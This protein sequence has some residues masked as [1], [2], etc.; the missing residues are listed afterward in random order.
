MAALDGRTPSTA[1]LL[2]TT[3]P[4]SSLSDVL[5]TPVGDAPAPVRG[6][7]GLFAAS[8]DASRAFARWLRPRKAELAAI[9]V[10]GTYLDDEDVLRLLNLSLPGI[11]EVIGLLEIV[12]M[13]N[14]NANRGY[15]RVV[16]DT[17]PTGHTMRLLEAPALLT[18]V[19]AV[20]DALQSHHRAV[21]AA[22]RGGYAADA[23]DAFI[24]ELDRDGRALEG[25]LRDP[26]STELTWVTLPEP[27]ALEETFDAI[28]ALQSAG[29]RVGRLIVNRFTPEAPDGCAFCDARRR[30][31]AR[32]LV[33]VAR[34]LGG[35]DIQM[36]PDLGEEPR[37]VRALERAAASFVPFAPVRSL[38]PI[39]HRVRA[40]IPAAARSTPRAVPAFRPEFLAGEVRWLLFGGKGGVGKSTCAAAASLRLAE[41]RRVLLLSTDPAHSLADVFG[42]PLDD[43]ARPIPGGPSSLHVREIDASAGFARYRQRYVDA[44]DETF[45][46]ISRS[47]PAEQPAFRDL[48]DL[49]PPGIDEVIAIAEVASALRAD[50]GAY[51]LVVTD[52]APTGHALRLLHT[53]AIL[54][55]WTKALMTILRKYREIV[56]AG[57]LAALL[58]ELSRRLRGLQETLTDA[59]RTRFVVVTRAAGLPV[60]EAEDLIRALGQLRIAVGALVVNALGRGD[61]A[62]CGR[63]SRAETSEVG[64]LR[65]LAGDGPYAIIGAPAEVPPPHGV[66]ALTDWGGAWQR[67]T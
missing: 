2:V 42:T 35:R 10:R 13:A 39:E 29:I 49:A 62:R 63:A 23:S 1:T 46:R 27:M 54:H 26:A 32:A 48:L 65:R 3:D 57:S 14:G 12:R 38:P 47:A 36:L 11:D 21:V 5:G 18:R 45:A 19:A 53:P 43:R 17:A 24:Q 4:A 66:A 41:S 50:D 34:R 40:P 64:R 60:E 22:L 8:L 25:L 37:G 59:A 7:K 16:V 52:T 6:A 31:E 33:P 51:D 30:F 9:A 61:C 55:D 20:L 56:G 44:V 67:L 58:V 28:A 15:D